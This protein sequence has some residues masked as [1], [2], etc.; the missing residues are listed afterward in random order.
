MTAKYA[1]IPKLVSGGGINAIEPR[2]RT[3]PVIAVRIKLI[4]KF[5]SSLYIVLFCVLSVQKI[6]FSLEQTLLK[7]D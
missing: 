3:V 5:I 4:M 1:N 6:P 7:S 2:N